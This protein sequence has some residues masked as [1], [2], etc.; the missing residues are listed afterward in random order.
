[1]ISLPASAIACGALLAGSTSTVGSEA[2]RSRFRRSVTNRREKWRIALRKSSRLA[3][4]LVTVVL[5]G[6]GLSEHAFAY[7]DPGSGSYLLQYVL[8]GTFASIF[9]LKSMWADVWATL[10]KK[11][12]VEDE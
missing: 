9:S 7:V 8:A 12:R 11:P 1:M 4:V 2:F 3:P 6:I 10:R 5:V